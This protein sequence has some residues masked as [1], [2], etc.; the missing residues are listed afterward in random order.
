M[1][2]SKLFLFNFETKELTSKFLCRPSASELNNGMKIFLMIKVLQSIKWFSSQNPLK[3]VRERTCAKGCKQPPQR[4][5]WQ[6][7]MQKAHKKLQ[8]LPETQKFPLKK[9]ITK[10]KVKLS[11]IAIYL[12]QKELKFFHW[13][14]SD[15]FISNKRYTIK[16]ERKFFS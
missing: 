5:R 1:I 11:N 12:H 3:L 16:T 6:R 8:N 4:A 13:N 14:K 10:R 7:A 15:E 2:K 9:V